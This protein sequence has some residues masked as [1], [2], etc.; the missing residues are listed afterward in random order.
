MWSVLSRTKSPFNAPIDSG[1]ESDEEC[2]V[3]TASII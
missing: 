3:M 2:F 1:D